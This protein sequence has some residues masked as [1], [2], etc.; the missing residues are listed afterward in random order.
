MFILH[1]LSWCTLKLTWG[2]DLSIS[3][4]HK[5]DICWKSRG[6]N[7]FQNLQHYILHLFICLTRLEPLRSSSHLQERPVIVLKYDLKPIQTYGE[8]TNSTQSGP[9]LTTLPPC[10]PIK[11]KLREN[12]YFC[13]KQNHND[14]K[15]TESLC[16]IKSCTL[17]GKC[18][19]SQLITLYSENCP[20]V[21][22]D[23]I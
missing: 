8:H 4:R 3:L 14:I 20:I 18:D 9:V 22:K 11:T 1:N 21:W 10:C 7:F 23:N 15:Y 13:L 5:S 2:L 16:Y 12:I 17:S 6:N 19:I